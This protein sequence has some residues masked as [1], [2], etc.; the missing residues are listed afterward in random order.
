MCTNTCCSVAYLFDCLI[1]G[2][3]FAV[4]G[5]L[6]LSVTD[7]LGGCGGGPRF[8]VLISLL[9]FDACCCAFICF[10]IINVLDNSVL[11]SNVPFE[12]LVL[13]FC[14]LFPVDADADDGDSIVGDVTPI[15]IIH[16]VNGNSHIML[17][18]FDHIKS[19]F[20]VSHKFHNMFGFTYFVRRL[21][22]TLA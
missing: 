4:A 22:L 8:L 6:L 19:D 21:A 3:L 11:K 16:H 13:V 1:R 17:I 20:N 5:L 14:G 15:A 7:L 9:V 2:L 18:S 10:F 12:L